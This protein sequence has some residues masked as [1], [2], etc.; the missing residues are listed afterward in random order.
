M[1]WV[2]LLGA[3]QSVSALAQSISPG[4][5]GT[6][7]PK[8][9]VRWSELETWRA[10]ERRDATILRLLI[11]DDYFRFGSSL[12][13]LKERT[14][15]N[16][17]SGPPVPEGQGP[18][19]PG[20]L[21]IRLFGPNTAVVTVDDFIGNGRG[22]TLRVVHA[23]DVWTKADGRWQLCAGYPVRE[24][25]GADVRAIRAGSA[26][27]NR[28]YAVKDTALF[29]TLLTPDFQMTT[30]AGSRTGR[31]ENMAGMARLLQKRPDLTLVFTPDK[32][33]AGADTGA[34]AGTWTER[35]TEPDGPERRTA[36]ELGGSYL[37]LWVKG[38]DGWRQKS[39]L[40]VPTFCKGGAYCR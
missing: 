34:E 38:S 29:G 22:D 2:C 14:I 11:H 5:Y 13:N 23:T 8:E 18:D 35:W 15:A 33:E 17:T 28:A 32:V 19:K 3:L 4:H 26:V 39:L 25:L 7:S 27:L 30:G 36:T 31:I 12:T 20:H 6:L 9:Q 1:K 37:I 21:Q 24:Q 16:W 10:S 40:L